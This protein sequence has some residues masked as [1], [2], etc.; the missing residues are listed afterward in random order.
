MI[1]T[2]L[3][4]RKCRGCDNYIVYEFGTQKFM[5]IYCED[6]HRR[7]NRLAADDYYRS[8]VDDDN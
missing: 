4:M 1:L 3:K 7:Y 6:C 5:P 8:L 2:D